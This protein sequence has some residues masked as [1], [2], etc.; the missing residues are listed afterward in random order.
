MSCRPRYAAVVMFASLLA[1]RVASAQL[2]APAAPAPAAPD[3]LEHRAAA[4]NAAELAGE[5]ARAPQTFTLG[6][7][8][9]AFYQWNFNRPANGI[10]HYR[11]FD[12]R[13]ATFTLANVALDAQW[14]HEGVVGRV[15]LQVG[16]TPATYYL[17]E[18]SAPGAAGTSDSDAGLWRY[19][20][21][22]YVGYRFGVGRGL[23]VS[24]GLFLSP[25]G[26]EGMAIHDNWNWSRSN[27]FFGLPFYHTGLRVAYPLSDAWALTVSAYN[28]WNSVVDNNAE[29]SV[30]VNLTYALPDRLAVSVL[31][32]A[33]V[34]RAPGAPEG[35]AWRHLLDAHVTWSV[36]PAVTLLAHA[37]AGFEPNA[38]GTSAWV[39]GA[40]YARLRVRPR[41]FLVARGDAFYES[42]ARDASGAASPIFWPVAW[43]ASGTA[44]VDYRPHAR[45]SFRLEYR[46]DQAAGEMFFGREAP[47]PMTPG[48]RSQD[49]VTAGLTTWF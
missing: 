18:P 12:N 2:P 19:V 16:H 40:L 7:Y 9:E 47:D 24:A 15:A 4:S 41:L 42:A 29:K 28:G 31:Y 14:D 6:G 33:G 32:F 27:L 49:T 22:A 35:R 17:A 13:H 26:P 8:A 46:H 10:T 37:N 23:L 11:G 1:G 44:T 21:Q 3:A 48:R 5:S 34:E 45:V 20:Q 43:V 39:A 25:I 36:T 38:F 30:A